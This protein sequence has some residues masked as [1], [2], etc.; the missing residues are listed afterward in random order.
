M[1]NQIIDLRS[2]TVT[3]PSP[4]MRRAMNE[5]PLGDD[6]YGED[7]TVNQLE[8]LA[9]ELLDKE[10]AL[11][12]P[13]GTMGNLICL[14]VHCARGE[15]YIV[16]DKQHT[17]LSE[18]GG[19]AAV[20]SIHP[21]VLPSQPDGKLKLAAIEAAIRGDDVHYPRTRLVSLENTHNRGGGRV[22][23]LAYIHQVRAIVER[24]ALRLHC[25]GARLWN[26]AIALGLSPAEVAAPFDSLSVCLSKGLAAPVGSLVVG[27]RA[28]IAEARRARKLLGGGMR[29]AGI[30]AAAGIVALTEMIER[31][32]D[33][34]ANALRLAEGLTSLGYSLLHPVETNIIYFEIPGD[35]NPDKRVA[36]WRERGLLIGRV[37]GRSCRAVTHY[38]IEVEDIERTLTIMAE[39]D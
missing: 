28:F 15:E 39:I 26:A 36:R 30:I 13:S 37:Y 2:D 27:T 22:L 6:V 24:R 20:G 5:A 17:Y 10:A 7:P 19:A 33:D 9:A 29:Q 11:F 16:G 4:A 14:L 31:L 34:Q 32:V 21:R 12:V 8:S 25:D 23:D 35:D 1:T 18:A 3:L 38:G